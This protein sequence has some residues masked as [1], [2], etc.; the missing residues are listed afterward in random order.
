MYYYDQILLYIIYYV[1]QNFVNASCKLSLRLSMLCLAPRAAQC[2][3]YEMQ[4]N[5]LPP[6]LDILII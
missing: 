2:L 3:C 5:T 6:L 4:I 1:L